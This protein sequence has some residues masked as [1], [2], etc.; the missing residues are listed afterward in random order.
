MAHEREC[1]IEAGL[2]IRDVALI[3]FVE[4]AFSK[5]DRLVKPSPHKGVSNGSCE[6]ATTAFYFASTSSDQICLASRDHFAKIL[7][8]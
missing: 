6:H 3:Y 4:M 2:L 7:R 8:A 1:L 5:R